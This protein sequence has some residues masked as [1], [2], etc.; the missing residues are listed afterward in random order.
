MPLIPPLNIQSISASKKNLNLRYTSLKQ[1]GHGSHGMVFKA[2]DEETQEDVAIKIISIRHDFDVTLA[3]NEVHIMKTLQ[4]DNVVNFRTNYH[5]ETSTWI[6]MDYYENGSVAAYLNSM[7]RGLPESYI[8]YIVQE[9][10]KGLVYLHQNKIIHYDLKCGNLLVDND[11]RIK[12]TDF[13]TAYHDAIDD[14]IRS[15]QRGS[16][17]WMSPE[18]IYEREQN[19]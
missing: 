12:I 19:E 7:K 11:G 13:G 16:L 18:V 14:S 5:D 6:V 3:C 4:H 15:M 10:L 2:H 17:P 9:V 8:I 1:I